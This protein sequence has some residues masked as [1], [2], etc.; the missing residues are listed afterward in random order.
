MNI[1]IFVP[2]VLAKPL[3][4]AQIVRG[5]FCL[6]RYMATKIPFIKTFGVTTKP[7]HIAHIFAISVWQKVKNVKSSSISYQYRTYIATF[8]PF[9][10]YSINN[11]LIIDTMSK[12]TYFSKKNIYFSQRKLL[13]LQ[14]KT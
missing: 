5:V 14:A 10:A 2:S 7:S 6:Y 3:N 8:L 9:G 13:Y 12:N 11:Q 4:N 1:R